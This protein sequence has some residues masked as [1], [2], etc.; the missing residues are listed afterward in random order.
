MTGIIDRPLVGY[1]SLLPL[2]YERKVWSFFFFKL[3][4]YIVCI[5]QNDNILL[6]LGESEQKEQLQD[7]E[8]QDVS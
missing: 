8:D 6:I 4:S 3:K 1:C 5:T 2:L 7:V